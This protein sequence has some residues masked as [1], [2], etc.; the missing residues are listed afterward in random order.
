MKMVTQVYIDVLWLNRLQ[1][2]VRC[3]FDTFKIDKEYFE[4]MHACYPFLEEDDLTSNQLFYVLKDALLIYNKA[5]NY[6]V[7]FGG[8]S[9]AVTRHLSTMSGIPLVR[10]YSHQFN[11]V[12]RELISFLENLSNALKQ[13][14]KLMSR[15]RTFKN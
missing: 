13:A 5:I 14:R 12:V 10:C 3:S 4:V 8:N 9:F 11:L 7:C 2:T 15:L 1:N 6:V